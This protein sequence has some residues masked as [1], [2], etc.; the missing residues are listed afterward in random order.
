[1][2]RRL[3]RDTENALLGGVTSGLASY[4]RS[5]DATEAAALDAARG[6]WAFGE[7]C[8]R[9]CTELGEAEAPAR[10]AALLRDWVAAGLI[11]RTD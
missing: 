7:L 9:L 4:F 8:E 6:G 5:L 1:M 11:S 2:T 3:T 10:A